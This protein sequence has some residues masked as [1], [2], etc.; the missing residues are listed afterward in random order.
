VKYVPDR[1]WKFFVGLILALGGYSTMIFSAA[2]GINAT[3]Y[4]WA[5]QIRVILFI[6]GAAI[7][8]LTA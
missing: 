6:L 7:M 5:A 1:N 8:L 4:I 3:I 2:A